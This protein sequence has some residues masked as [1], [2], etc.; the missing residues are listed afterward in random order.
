M[1][2]IIDNV[3]SNAPVLLLAAEDLIETLEPLTATEPA[4]VSQVCRDIINFGRDQLNKSG[5]SWIFVADKLTNIALTLHRQDAYREAGLQLFEQLISLNVREARD[6]IELLDRRPIVSTN[7][8]QRPRWR[9][10]SR[11]TRIAVRS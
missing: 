2:L 5:T 7:Y 4:L 6:A 10:R 1:R 11:R 8:Q 9:R 3:C